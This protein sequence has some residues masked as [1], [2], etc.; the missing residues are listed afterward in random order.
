[1]Y[2]AAIPH[3]QPASGLNN[4]PGTSQ[5]SGYP[6]VSFHPQGGAYPRNPAPRQQQQPVEYTQNMNESQYP[7]HHQPTQPLQHQQ[8][9]QPA[10]G[11]QYP[12]QKMRPQYQAGYQQ[13]AQNYAPRQ[14]THQY[15]PQQLP[16]QYPP[17][18][19]YHQ[20]PQ[21]P[22]HQQIP[23]QQY[24]PQTRA[25]PQNLQPPSLQSSAP[26]PE[27]YLSGSSAI[28]GEMDSSRIHLL[29]EKIQ[30]LELQLKQSSSPSVSPQLN[31]WPNRDVSDADMS[32][33][34][35]TELQNSGSEATKKAVTQYSGDESAEESANSNGLQYSRSI[36]RSNFDK[37]GFKS[38]RRT[39]PTTIEPINEAMRNSASSS[40]T[41]NEELVASTQSNPSRRVR[42]R[43]PENEMVTPKND[44]DG[45]N[46][47]GRNT[48]SSSNNGD[49]FVS[50][51]TVPLPE[52]PTDFKNLPARSPAPR[53]QTLPKVTPVTSFNRSE[54]SLPRDRDVRPSFTKTSSPDEPSI[55]TGSTSGLKGTEYGG[56]IPSVVPKRSFDRMVLD[57]KGARNS[58]IQDYKF[59]TPKIQFD[60]ARTLLEAISSRD[61]ML[62]MAID[63]SIRKRPASEKDLQ[64]IKEQFCSTAV[65]VLKK[66]VAVDNGET[67]AKLYLGDLLSGGIHPG[68]VERDEVKGYSMF[69]EAAINDSDPVAMYRVGCCLEIGVGTQKSVG[70]ALEFFNKASEH[71]DPSAMC[72][73]GIL[74]FTGQYGRPRDVE[75]S[76]YWHIQAARTLSKTSLMSEDV[77]ITARSFSDAR[78]ALYTL[79]KIYHTDLDVLCLNT[80]TPN[81]LDTIDD[82]KRANAFRNQIKAME[83]YLEAA[84][85]GHKDSQAC[86]GYVFATGYLPTH[87][88]RPD[89]AASNGSQIESPDARKSIYW[90]SKAAEKN[91]PLASMGL[92]IWY[93]DGVPGILNSDPEQGFLWVRKGAEAGCANAEFLL[94]TY[95]EN[96]LGTIKSME[97]A[98]RWYNR[99]AS[100]GYSKAIK[101]LQKA[102]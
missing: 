96:G 86:L 75:K 85:L 78:G 11:K 70:R 31:Q 48:S 84:R 71:G 34:F 56:V 10:F 44:E 62:K 63:G 41:L 98:L 87:S 42:R 50:S 76:I 60:W 22:Q 72:Q 1:M 27:R 66:V 35:P 49:T 14:Q 39:E 100:Q 77:L 16:Q 80:N 99:A 15:P 21:Y 69:Y 65:K 23:P 47:G 53:Q 94:G 93:T 17:Q 7:Q 55:R 89:K 81:V 102:V 101:R 79:A 37:A 97:Q 92:G 64:T 28:S 38:I 74:E 90:Y 8:Q 73:L 67:R 91:H 58:A 9:Q 5:R 25:P 52:L 3:H 95:Y 30:K 26:R 61:M 40:D 51:R 57:F 45:L 46:F 29:E 13:P 68:L 32:S 36:Y 83:Y 20:H 19:Q 43:F 88:F 2:N 59:F 18:Q 12:P 54:D 33:T 24:Q 4:G 82:L 6:P